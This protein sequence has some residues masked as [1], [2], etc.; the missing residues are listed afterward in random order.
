[1]TT[2]TLP[3]DLQAERSILGA[4]LINE[5]AFFAISGLQGAH[6]FREG[7]RYI[8]E[9]MAGL[10][11]R[12]VTPDTLT[13][14]DALVRAQRL[15][16]AGGAAYLAGLV[17]GVPKTTN[18]EH[19]AAIVTRLW[20]LREV[21]HVGQRMV[22][23][24]YAGEDD[25]D[26]VLEDAQRDLLALHDDGGRRGAVAASTAIDE[27]APVIERILERQGAVLGL[28]TGY[29]DL[30]AM[31][32]GF[33]PS[34]LVLL[35]GRT[36]MGKT[37]LAGNIAEHVAARGETV[38][39]FSLEMNRDDVMLRMVAS[40]ARV[41]FHRFMLAKIAD[42]DVRRLSE[43]MATIR[44]YPLYVNDAPEASLL[45]LRAT[46]RRVRMRQGLALVIVDYLQMMGGNPKAESRQQ[47]V[48]QISRG[49]KTLAKDLQVPVVAL[50]Q[51]S[52]EAV[53]RG[54]DHRP[55]LSDLRE[56]GSLEQDADQVWFVHRPEVYESTD[57]NRGVAEVIV[58]KSR[59]GP[60]G[61]V[62]L[63]WCAGEMR[64]ENF[65]SNEAVADRLWN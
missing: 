39:F 14:R 63:T 44:Q 26:T 10:I 20:R 34:D 56:S 22:S 45:D 30:D 61:I 5:D 29:H 60:T 52:R 41:D 38:V 51:L 16:E 11:E 17:D 31:T 28:S 55:V 62:N 48:S 24:A 46:C 12:N 19:Y 50:S 2:P 18:V 36:S 7:H 4:V 42:R 57:A 8:W 25:P 23:D 49:L 21:I 13:L 15:E 3:H 9:A 37:S 58:A 1:M 54:G 35:A 33:R 59:N 32:R 65:A 27:L 6:F 64:F 40:N 43:S 47:A 53:K